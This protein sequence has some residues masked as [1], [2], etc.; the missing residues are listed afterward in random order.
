MALVD[1]RDY[2]LSGIYYS[3]FGAK[4]LSTLP[5]NTMLTQYWS[6]AGPPSATLAHHQT[7]IGSRSPNTVLMSGQRRRP[8]IGSTSRA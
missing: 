4:H 6:N 7:S 3:V 8:S 2:V 5:A 1:S